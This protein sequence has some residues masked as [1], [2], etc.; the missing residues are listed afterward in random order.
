MRSSMK[1]IV[2]ETSTT[3]TTSSWLWRDQR[4]V[5]AARLGRDRGEAVGDAAGDVDRA[6][7]RVAVH[8]R[9]RRDVRRDRVPR[10]AAPRRVR[11]GPMMSSTKSTRSTP[12]TS[13]TASLPCV[14]EHVAEGG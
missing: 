14:L 6:V 9:R 1:V 4:R 7:A 3:N 2:V 11:R 5:L 13:P 10:R 12:S 8:A